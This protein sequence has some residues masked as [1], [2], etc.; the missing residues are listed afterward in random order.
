MT[1]EQ[2]FK[3]KKAFK[4]LAEKHIKRECINELISYLET[5]TDFFEAPASTKYHGSEAGGLCQHSINVGKQ[6]FA[7]APHF[8]PGVEFSSESLAIVSL[9]HDICKA[10]CYKKDVKNQ[11]NNETGQWEKVDYFRFEEDFPFGG[12]GSK[13]VFLINEFMKLTREEAAAIN[14]HMGFSDTTNINAISSVYEKNPIAWLLHVADEAATY[15]D[16]I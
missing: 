5:E 11:K 10:G 15:V 1:N 13:S 3:N 6:L 4:A 12:H 16:K 2:I 9:F 14:C 7:T 8:F